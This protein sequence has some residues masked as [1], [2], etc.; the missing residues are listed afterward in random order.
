[1]YDQFF[2]G[3][4]IWGL[5]MEYTHRSIFAAMRVGY[6]AGTAEIVSALHEAARHAGMYP[7]GSRLPVHPATLETS[8]VRRLISSP[9]ALTLSYLIA[10]T[11]STHP[12]VHN[13]HGGLLRA[14]CI[15][16]EMDIS[17]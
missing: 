15:G 9:T 10:C 1:M 5:T 6:M 17:K 8:A 2:G 13:W 16:I 14:K 7:G 4:R 3:R 11:L 12:A